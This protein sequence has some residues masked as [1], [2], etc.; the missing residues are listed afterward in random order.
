MYS[1]LQKF[2]KFL[3]RKIKL[4]ILD[5]IMKMLTNLISIY[6]HN[7]IHVCSRAKVYTTKID[8]MLVYRHKNRI[9]AKK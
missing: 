2:F 5:K 3:T 6:D 1:L 7:I 4:F 9:G 8:S